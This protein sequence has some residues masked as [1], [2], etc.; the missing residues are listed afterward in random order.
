MTKP[1]ALIVIDIQNDYMPDGS[2]PLWQ[3]DSVTERAAAAISRA[4]AAEMPVILVQHIVDPSKGPSSF[5]NEATEGVAIHPAIRAAAPSA[6]V[7]VKRFADAFHQTNLSA[8]LEGLGVKEIVLCGMMT[9]N[10]VTHTALSKS[11]EPYLVH[12]LSDLCTTVSEPVHQ[13]A[14]SGLAVRTTVT[15]ADLALA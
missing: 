1:A 15:T 10:C 5:F 6:P 14:L 13:I 11:A 7:V 8:L 4:V 3:A 9:Q 12:I 2:F